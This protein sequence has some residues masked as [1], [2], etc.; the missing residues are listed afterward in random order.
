MKIVKKIASV[1]KPKGNMN[2]T[3]I[4]TTLRDMQMSLRFMEAQFREGK[5]Q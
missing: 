2:K 1:P 4:L 3:Q 5:S